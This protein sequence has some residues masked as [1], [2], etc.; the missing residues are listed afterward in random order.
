MSCCGVNRGNSHFHRMTS[1]DISYK[2]GDVHYCYSYVVVTVAKY[3]NAISV[4][5]M[6]G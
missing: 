6:V 3:N 5:I 4:I 1:H 2:Y